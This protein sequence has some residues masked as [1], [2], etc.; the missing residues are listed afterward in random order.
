MYYLCPFNTTNSLVSKPSWQ[1]MYIFLRNF[2]FEMYWKGHE[3]GSFTVC[4]Q[5]G[6]TSRKILFH[7]QDGNIIIAGN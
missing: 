6:K 3:I 2:L 7:I 1:E 4:L 5:T